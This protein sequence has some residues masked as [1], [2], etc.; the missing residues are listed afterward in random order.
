LKAC[1]GCR[2][3]I[4][5]LAERNKGSCST[6]SDFGKLSPSPAARTRERR[7][8]KRKGKPFTEVKITAMGEELS[9]AGMREKLLRGEW[10]MKA[11]V[12]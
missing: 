3:S 9:K 8:T 7:A 1:E 4:R 11:T 6:L 12:G 5:I 2:P 10:P